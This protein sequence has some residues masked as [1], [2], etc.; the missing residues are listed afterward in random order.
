MGRSGPASLIL[1]GD[2]RKFVD[3]IDHIARTRVQVYLSALQ[4]VVT[5]YLLNDFDVRLFEEFSGE[6][7]P[8]HVRVARPVY[9]GDGV[10]SECLMEVSR[11]EAII[12]TQ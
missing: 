8:E 11:A 12:S 3:G 10:P 7:V 1:S 2:E 6:G 5:E 4:A 9:R